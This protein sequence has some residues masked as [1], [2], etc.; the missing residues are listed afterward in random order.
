MSSPFTQCNS[1]TTAAA[2]SRLLLHHRPLTPCTSPACWLLCKGRLN[3]SVL[4]LLL[5]LLLTILSLLA[6]LQL[7]YYCW[8]YRSQRARRQAFVLEHGLL[9][10]RRMQG[11]DKR[12][13]AGERERYAQ[14]RVFAR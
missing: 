13:M 2:T 4:L 8:W 9:N 3:V 5:L 12:R 10:V 1:C 6:S 7:P 14:M 11:L